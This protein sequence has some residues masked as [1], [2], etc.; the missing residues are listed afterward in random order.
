MGPVSWRSERL[1]TCDLVKLTSRQ[2]P[3]S[4]LFRLNFFCVVEAIYMIP[5]RNRG[6]HLWKDLFRGKLGRDIRGMRASTTWWPRLV[7]RWVASSGHKSV[8]SAFLLIHYSITSSNSD[9]NQIQLS[10]TKVRWDKAYVRE[11]E[12]R[13][14]IVQHFRSRRKWLRQMLP[15]IWRLRMVGQSVTCKLLHINWKTKSCLK[16]KG[17][18]GNHGGW[19]VWSPLLINPLVRVKVVCE[20]RD[21]LAHTK[22]RTVL[23]GFTAVVCYSE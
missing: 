6:H 12:M 20:F 13:S 17:I 23:F 10:N 15:H 21:S 22:T 4:P 14:F 5:Y 9:S 19:N 16:W 11:S 3:I 7:G 8:F 18:Y 1:I 2:F